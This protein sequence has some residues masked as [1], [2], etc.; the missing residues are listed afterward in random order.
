MLHSERCRCVATLQWCCATTHL[1]LKLTRMNGTT[2]AAPVD[3]F[4]TGRQS[5]S[6]WWQNRQVRSSL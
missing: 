1:P 5:C 6:S 3:C 4:M 2:S